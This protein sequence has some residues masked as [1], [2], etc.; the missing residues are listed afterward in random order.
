M[1]RKKIVVS[2]SNDITNDQRVHR[3][4]MSLQKFGYDVLL[5]GRTMKSSQNIEP[6]TYEIKRFRLLFNSGFL[7]YTFFNIRLFFYL[8]FCKADIFLSNDLDTLLGNTLAAKIKKVKLVYDSHEFFTEVPE[9]EN[10]KFKKKIWLIIEKYSIKK[11]DASYTVCSSIAEIYNKKYGINM[12]VVRN[13]PFKKN[14]SIS[15]ENRENILLYQG[16]LNKERGIEIL[17]KAM[18]HLPY[19]NLIIAG[20]GY[21]EKELKNLAAELKLTDRIIFT[22]NICFNELHN[23]TSKAKLGFSIEQ[24]K[25]FNYYYALP[26]KIFDYIQAG[27]PIICSDF[28]E[29]KNIINTCNVGEI[30]NMPTPEGL[31][32]QVDELLNK[33]EKL[34]YYHDNCLVAKEILNWENEEEKLRKIFLS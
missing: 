24:G 18:K 14:I 16:T 32:L 5:I 12:Q 29:M 23:I 11:T 17:I 20:K 26:N 25:S 13:L 33:P 6:R 34:K 19:C 28:P 3:I 30:L 27:V 9:L 15:Y 7:F 10:T 4:C 22:G 2:V 31:S 8:L 21:L 1:Q